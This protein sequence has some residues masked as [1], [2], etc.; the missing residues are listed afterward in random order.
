[1]A[2]SNPS[3]RIGRNSQSVPPS[4]LLEAHLHRVSGGFRVAPQQFEDFGEGL[5]VA[6]S[7]CQRHG[8]CNEIEIR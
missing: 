5:P 1:M 8:L 6:A 3:R 2:D 7:R 4:I